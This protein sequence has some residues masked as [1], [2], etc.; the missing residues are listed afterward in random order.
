MFPNGIKSS[1]PTPV[2][3]TSN[4]ILPAALDPDDYLR[5][6]AD[7][8]RN[9]PAVFTPGTPENAAIVD[10][11]VQYGPASAYRNANTILAPFRQQQEAGG[12][13]DPSRVFNPSAFLV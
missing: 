2:G 9:N 11:A 1:L 10:H 8:Y 7:L 12:P 6:H 13:A 4:N 3:V 5:M